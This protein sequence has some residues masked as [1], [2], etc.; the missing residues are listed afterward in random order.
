MEHLKDLLET[1]EAHEPLDP[2][3]LKGFFLR[4]YSICFVLFMHL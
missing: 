4:V 2:V 3:E 1:F